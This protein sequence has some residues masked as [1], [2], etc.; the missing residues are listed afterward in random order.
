MNIVLGVAIAL[1]VILEIENIFRGRQIKKLEA[2]LPVLNLAR[3]EEIY[4]ACVAEFETESVPDVMKMC[5]AT[6][7]D[8]GARLAFHTELRKEMDAIRMRLLGKSN[9]WDVERFVRLQAIHECL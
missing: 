5:I 6:S 9:S 8:L 4:D 1:I 7:M 2:R 3:L